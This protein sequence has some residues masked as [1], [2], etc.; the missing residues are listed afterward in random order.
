MATAP[1]Q[2]GLV[3]RSVPNTNSLERS[4]W[5]VLR[6]AGSLKITCAMFALGILILLVGTLAQD[7]ETIVDVKRSYFNSWVAKVDFDV[8]VPQTI[9][10]H[11]KAYPGFFVMPGGATI[12]LILLINLVAAKMTRFHMTARGARFAAG[13]AITLLGFALIAM[14]V[15]GAHLGDGLQGEPPFDYDTIWNGCIASLWLSIL[16]LGAWGVFASP[17]HSIS[18]F[19]LWIGFALVLAVGIILAIAGDAVRIPDPGLRIVW[20]LA[21]SLI[22]SAVML[23][24]LTILFGGR[25]GNVLIHLGIGLLM[26]GQFAFGDRQREER[27]S[28][29]EG[30]RTRAAVQTDIV[31]LAV[32]DKTQPDKD[33]VVAFDDPLISKAATEKSLLT[34]SS[35]PFEIRVEKWMPNSDLKPRRSD[36]ELAKEAEGVAGLPPELALVEVLKSGGAKSEMNIASAYISIREKKTSKELGRFA[37]SQLLNDTTFRPQNFLTTIESDGRQFDLALRFRRNLKP[38]A[39]ELTNVELK[40]Y[41]G[42]A[43]PKDYSSY[44]RIVDDSGT[45]LQ[46][47]RIWM[48]SPMRFRGETY[49]QSSYAPAAQTPLG[50]EQT[51]LQVVTNAGWLIPYVS[52]VLVGLGML[53]HFSITLTRFASRYDRKAIA[54]TDRAPWYLTAALI[55]LALLGGWLY[56]RAKTPVAKE[57]NIDWYAIGELPV[58][59]E[60]RIKPLAGVGAQVLKALSDKPFALSLEG[61]SYEGAQETGKQISAAQWLMSVMAHEPWVMEAPLVRID[62]I[63]LL[64]EL[65]LD[66]HKSHRYSIKQID[67]KLAGDNS[68]TFQRK[69]QQLANSEESSWT[70]EDRNF[71]RLQTR[72]GIFYSIWGAYEPIDEILKTVANDPQKLSQVIDGLGPVMESIKRK[73][74]PAI[75]PPTDLPEKLDPSQPPPQWNAFAPAFYEVLKNFD[76]KKLDNPTSQFRQLT[77]VLRKGSSNSKQINEEVSKYA[78]MLEDKYSVVARSKKARFEAWYGHFN[79]ISIS[80]VLYIVA[81]LTA[82]L[83]LVCSAFASIPTGAVVKEWIRQAAFW[84]CVV[85]LLIHTV[86][87]I[88][89]IYISERPPVVSLYSAAVFIGWAIVLAGVVSELLF[90]ISIS[91]LVAAKAGY[92][93]LLVADGLDIGDS[94]PVLQAVLDTQFWLSTHVIS[95]SLG[96]SA[97]FLAGFLGIGIVLLAFFAWFAPSVIA[98]ETR[99]KLIDTLYRVCYGVVCFG[100]FFSFVGT[101]LGGLWGDDSWGRFWGWDPKENGALMIVLWNALLLHAKWDKLVGPLGFAMLA[102]GGNIITAWSMFGTNILGIGLHAYGGETGESL[103]N[104]GY[105]FASQLA[106]IL[107][108]GYVYFVTL[109]QKQTKTL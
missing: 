17:K 50:V 71:M 42:T 65:G 79:P 67:E 102:I 15:F 49:Y 77:Q 2:D 46:E 11:E 39:F 90:P 48:N 34:D 68:E 13:M 27:I 16:G 62:S 24:G 80:Y 88:S 28:L 47:G 14:I 82:F 35:L 8:F 70:V 108:G 64:D 78:N 105:F 89:R 21:K 6:Y 72:M 38:F 85:T 57:G 41:T 30:Q 97:T 51:V 104:M 81:A 91:L 1:L 5:T 109:A 106:I 83:G 29:Y 61:H 60:G 96:Y 74:P 75:I 76:P 92:L 32:I 36:P 87:I 107:L 69:F 94:M 98:E 25:G 44:V 9:W 95:V 56:N 37:V 54:L 19:A 43:I 45:T 100:I 101:V 10:R 52:C 26:I 55:P 86:A 23:S 40:Q 22:V 18:K 3:P 53:A 59:H 103:R 63:A 12:G 31:E 4:I 84:I 58:Q 73:G 99:K 20:Q 7:E 93:S 33:R 66:R